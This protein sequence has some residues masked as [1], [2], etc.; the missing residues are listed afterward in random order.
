MRKIE[1]FNAGDQAWSAWVSIKEHSPI[2]TAA[3]SVCL[4]LVEV[5]MPEG[6]IVQLPGGVP[7]VLYY[8]E[9]LF[10][11]QAEARQWVAAQ[12]AAGAASLAKQAADLAEPVVVTV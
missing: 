10:P 3:A 4:E 9:R 2:A 5:V 8:H 12:V 7:R 6:A 11:T 1:G